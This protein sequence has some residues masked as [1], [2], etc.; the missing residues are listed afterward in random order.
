M[1]LY[2]ETILDHYEH[3]HHAGALL[4]PDTRVAEYNVLCGDSIVLDCA[5]TRDG[6]IKDVAFTG[7]GCALSKASMSMLSDW[8]IG[9]TCGDIMQLSQKSVQELIGSPIIPGRLKCVMLGASALWQS[10]EQYGKK[11]KK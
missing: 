9:K 11:H 7:A 10:C 5:F 1:D 4:I 6:A 2:T 3:P 8:C